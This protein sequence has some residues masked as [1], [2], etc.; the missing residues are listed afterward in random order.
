MNRHMCLVCDSEYL[1]CGRSE[2]ERPC[3]SKR[4]RRLP[5]KALGNDGDRRRLFPCPLVP[6]STDHSSQHLC[7]H[8]YTTRGDGLENVDK[9]LSGADDETVCHVVATLP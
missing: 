4:T 2:E 7:W 3:C 5:V 8:F 1:Y 6:Y 9:M